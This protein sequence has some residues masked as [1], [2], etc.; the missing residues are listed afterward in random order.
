MLGSGPKSPND[1]RMAED[2]RK[3]EPQPYGRD[4]VSLRIEAIE[5][6]GEGA[7]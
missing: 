6:P 3:R 1:D 4:S 5:A 2:D 7:T